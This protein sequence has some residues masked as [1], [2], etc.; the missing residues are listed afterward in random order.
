[1][2]DNAYDQFAQYDADQEPDWL[3]KVRADARAYEALT[4]KT[5]GRKPEELIEGYFKL[6]REKRETSLADLFKAKGVD[7]RAAKFFPAEVEATEE[8][9]QAWLDGDGVV[10]KPAST[11]QQGDQTQQ[12]QQPS[13]IPEQMT[14]PGDA[15]PQDEVP[16]W[17][18][19]YMRIH[20]TETAGDVVPPSSVTNKQAALAAAFQ[21]AKS[22]QEFLNALREER[23]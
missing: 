2:A 15:K 19:Q 10:F 9:V 7:A 13:Q 1:M 8:S 14:P 17:M 21:N 16:P 22:S 3:K 4:K 18:S 20:E 11:E 6:E 12:Q 5:Q 23:I